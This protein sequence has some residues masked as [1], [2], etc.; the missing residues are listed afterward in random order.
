MSDQGLACA[1]VA[2]LPED[3]RQLLRAGSHME[4][5]N[6]D[7]IIAWARVIVKDEA[8]LGSSEAKQ[9]W[10]GGISASLLFQP[11]LNEV[12]PSIAVYVDGV[13]CQALVDIGCSRSIVHV[14]CCKTWK[15][16]TI[17]ML[18]VSGDEWLCE[19]TSNVQLELSGGVCAGVSVCV[20]ELTRQTL[21]EMQMAASYP[22]ARRTLECLEYVAYVNKFGGV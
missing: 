18:T 17:N 7:Q 2:G 13:K 21:V 12:L 14:S 6:L 15:K 8:T 4:A 20:T 3:V 5:L 16:H 11:P 1:F 22:G 19:G 9:A 10:R